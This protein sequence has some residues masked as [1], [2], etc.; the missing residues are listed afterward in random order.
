MQCNTGSE[1]TLRCGT[2]P[3]CQEH[4]TNSPRICEVLAVGIGDTNSEFRK[5][6]MRIFAFSPSQSHKPLVGLT[7]HISNCSKPLDAG[8][9]W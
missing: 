5:P 4:K 7:F 2:S 9:P 1:T 3:G 6:W 8:D